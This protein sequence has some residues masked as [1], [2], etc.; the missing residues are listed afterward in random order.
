MGTWL[1]VQTG[2]FLNASCRIWAWLH[3]EYDTLPCGSPDPFVG[4]SHAIPGFQDLSHA[5][6]CQLQDP[7]MTNLRN[8]HAVFSQFYGCLR[9]QQLHIKMNRMVCNQQPLQHVSP[10]KGALHK[11]STQ[12]LSDICSAHLGYVWFHP[13]IEHKPLRKHVQGGW[14]MQM[15][16]PSGQGSPLPT[17]PGK[18]SD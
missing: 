13:S 16:D 18:E 1:H 5:S 9:F 17:W 3:V 15:I 4:S 14:D 2:I 6:E 12:P 10:V 11:G 8:K 7:A